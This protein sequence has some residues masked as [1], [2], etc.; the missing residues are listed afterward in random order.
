M[1]HW[2]STVLS[3]F[4]QRPLSEE[5]TMFRLLDLLPF[6]GENM[7]TLLIN[8]VPY[9]EL[10]SVTG[11]INQLHLILS[12]KFCQWQIITLLWWVSQKL[13][14]PRLGICGAMLLLRLTPQG[15]ILN[16]NTGKQYLIIFFCCSGWNSLHDLWRGKCDCRRGLDW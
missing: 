15:M 1:A 8:N 14:L 13:I 3:D 9:E 10:I 5:N 7:G 12:P 4:L 2:F 11:Q 16:I 6:H